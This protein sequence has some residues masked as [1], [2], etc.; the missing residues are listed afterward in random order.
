MARFRNEAGGGYW[1]T[2]EYTHQLHCLVR[3]DIP[4]S[5]GQN[6]NSSN[7]NALR[8]VTFR[9]YYESRGDAFFN[10]SPEMLRTHIGNS[11]LCIIATSSIPEKYLQIIASRC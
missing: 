8:K 7:Q 5:I 11:P 2:I 1:T 9:D 3:I 4:Y 10:A 6:F